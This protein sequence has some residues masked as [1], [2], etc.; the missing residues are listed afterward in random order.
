MSVTWEDVV[1]H[2]VSLP[3]VAESTSYGTPALTV[4][5]KLMCGCAPTATVGSP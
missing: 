2:A 5:G 1:T 3:E 4:S